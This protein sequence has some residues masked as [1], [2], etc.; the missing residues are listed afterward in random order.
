[1]TNQG[2][3][4]EISNEKVEQFQRD[5]FEWSRGNLRSFPWR[6]TTD[7]FRIL[8][9]EFLLQ[10]TQADTVEPVYNRVLQKYPDFQSLAGS[11]KSDVVRLLRPLGLQNKRGRALSEIA[12]RLK[13]KPV[14]SEAEDLMDLPFIGRYS[15]NAILCFSFGERVPLL[16]GNIVR[17]YD[18]LFGIN[19]DYRS[20]E[21][22][23]FAEEVLPSSNVRRFNLALLDFGAKICQPDPICQECF[24]KGYCC[25]YS[26]KF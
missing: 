2:H 16:D 11:D 17:V 7:P 15:T 25:Y 6:E 4:Y 12:E 20:P 13:N 5:L 23:T 1:M 9:A 3:S 18:R 14:P 10:R 24:A 19:L 21:A 26:K 8:L 22:W